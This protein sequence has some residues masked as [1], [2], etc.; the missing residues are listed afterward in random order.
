MKCH[1]K[2]CFLFN[3]CHVSIPAFFSSPAFFSI[4]TMFHTLLSA[5]YIVVK[6]SL[7]LNTG[8]ILIKFEHVT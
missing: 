3:P 7:Q 2:S 5:G 6:M 4:P 1:Y 8:E